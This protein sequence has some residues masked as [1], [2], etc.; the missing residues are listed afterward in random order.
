MKRTAYITLTACFG[1]LGLSSLSAQN[2][3][4]NIYF[5]SGKHELSE[6]AKQELDRLVVCAKAEGDFDLDIL[7]YTDDIGS[8]KYNKELAQ[9]RAASVKNYLDAA[10]IRATDTRVEGL[11]ALALESKNNVNE[12]RQ[13]NRRVEVSFTPF[14]PESLN[15]FYSYFFQRNEQSFTIRQGKDQNIIGVKGTEV[16]IPAGSFQLQG[17]AEIDDEEVIITLREAYN[18]QDMV[19][20]NLSTVSHGELIE[21][22][23][24]LY[25]DA[26][27]ADGRPLEIRP[28]KELLLTMPSD[29]KLPDDMQL[30]YA[31]RDATNI[32]QPINWVATGQNFSGNNFDNEP[33]VF[34]FSGLRM[35]AIPNIEYP[36]LEELPQEQQKPT[37]PNAP[38][39]A[40]M[41]STNLP[42]KE[43]IAI[44]NPR[45]NGE[46][47]KKYEERIEKL[48]AD[49]QKQVETNIRLNESAQK[50][51]ESE[52]ANYEL[53][54]EKYRAELLAYN[55]Y[56]ELRANAIDML[57]FGRNDIEKWLSSFKWS[58]D[59]NKALLK[60]VGLTKNLDK[61][62]EYM[63]VE[64]RRLGLEAE[65]AEIAAMNF[66]GQKAIKIV[67]TAFAR[68]IRANYDFY[69]NHKI[70]EIK[71]KVSELLYV[72]NV[73]KNQLDPEK[74]R[75]AYAMIVG[76]NR[77]AELLNTLIDN[78]NEVLGKSG[79]NEET[80]NLDK[81]CIRLLQIQEKVLLIKQERGL[82]TQKEAKT[83]YRNT[84]GVNRL[85]W[86]NCDRFMNLPEEDKM[87]LSVLEEKDPDLEIFV[88]FEGI[89]GVMPFSPR[90]GKYMAGT[91][92][93]DKGARIIAI[94][95]KE[96][97]V[98][99]AV[100]Q[101]IVKDIKDL[102]LSFKAYKLTELRE[103]LG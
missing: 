3:K 12:Q 85:G 23:G 27:T 14:K 38:R 65:A 80:Q 10:Q 76:V 37:E 9:R 98:E 75:I 61:F 58:E 101:G 26:R 92:P 53:A 47:E 66:D 25:L 41:R 15:D 21:T 49:A 56:Q 44:D 13:E 39:K 17:G 78:Y 88:L 63:V 34:N 79:F 42:S 6:E 1:L 90:E 33:P 5:Q 32:A 22:G 4:T 40:S 54:K 77:H 97:K 82:L 69:N 59:F 16:F 93:K 100:H 57:K 87:M 91:A 43:E 31:D 99:A 50:R 29:G 24:M 74:A 48:Y 72:A 81:I 52:L 20:N 70:D 7:A 18:Y 71:S 86:I 19:L 36:G 64:C 73:E 51:Y 30:F 68:C 83:I 46:A 62:K 96:G 55:N 2:L 67:A 95:V 28:G 8:Q 89:N 84:V 102:K 45:K 11:G 103:L 60:T 35:P 94:R